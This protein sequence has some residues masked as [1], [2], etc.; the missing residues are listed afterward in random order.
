M[1]L[2]ILAA[3]CYRL[4]PHPWNVTPLGAMALLGGAYLGRRHAL[5]LPLMVLALTDLMLNVRMGYPMVYL[6]RAF[7]YAAFVLIGLLGL[8]MRTRS[9]QRKLAAALITPFIFFF[10]SN[11]GV[12]LFGNSLGN[13][14]YSYNLN[15]LIACYAAGLP[16]LRGTLIGD[17]GFIA[18]FVGSA[19]LAGRLHNQSLDR[20]LAPANA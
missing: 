14:P 8:W 1:M 3:G 10:I 5:W 2:M 13:V 7:D 9:T 18:I 20:L 4:M 12:W 11:F 15:G 16:F 19:W 17:W 6:P